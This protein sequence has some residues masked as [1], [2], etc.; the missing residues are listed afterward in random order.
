M[1]RPVI[2]RSLRNLRARAGV[3]FAG[4]TETASSGMSSPVSSSAPRTWSTSA[5]HVSWQ[6]EYTNVIA[7][8]RPA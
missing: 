4:S 7:N 3:S 2:R 5:G 1:A 8:G 6:V